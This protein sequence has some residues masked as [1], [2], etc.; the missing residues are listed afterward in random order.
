MTPAI[1]AFLLKFLSDLKTESAVIHNRRDTLHDYF[2]PTGERFHRHECGRHSLG[3][4]ARSH[5]FSLSADQPVI[6]VIGHLAVPGHF[7]LLAINHCCYPLS[8]NAL[9]LRIAER[10]LRQNAPLISTNRVN[11]S[12]RPSSIAKHSIHFAKLLMS[13]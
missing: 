11:T 4:V 8:T 7:S 6:P 2:L 3:P 10:Y 5:D 1:K 9:T 13:A 12:R